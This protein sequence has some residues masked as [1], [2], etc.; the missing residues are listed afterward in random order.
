MFRR[1]VNSRNYFDLFANKS[2]LNTMPNTA[3]R[4]LKSYATLHQQQQKKDIQSTIYYAAAVVTTF[5]GL[6]FAA[7]PL[8]QLFCSS[9]GIDGTPKTGKETMFL[10]DKL[11]V[12]GHA[13]PIKITFDSSV[14]E[15]MPWEFSPETRQLT[16][17]AG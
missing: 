4:Q 15:I 2:K 7:V 12:P 17:K 5:V 8:Y 3:N 11:F 14:S 10:L 16:V 13:K 6:S 1:I 9:T